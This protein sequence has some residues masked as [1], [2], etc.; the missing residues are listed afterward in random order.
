MFCLLPFNS[1]SISAVKPV[2][3]HNLPFSKKEIKRIIKNNEILHRAHAKDYK[4]RKKIVWQRLKLKTA[5]LH[6]KSCS[7]ALRKLSLYENYSQYVGVIKKSTYSEKRGRI[8]LLLDAMVLPNAMILE[9]KIPRITKTGVYPFKFEKGFLKN[10]IGSIHVS[11]YKNKCLFF[12]E[13]KW[14]GKHT[15]FPNYLLE[16]FSSTLITLGMNNLF[17]VSATY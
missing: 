4:K 6:K 16:L 14:R 2:T 17:R 5:G 7:F 11:N 9:F 3:A 1:F 15:G 12:I 10:L 13:A 8:H